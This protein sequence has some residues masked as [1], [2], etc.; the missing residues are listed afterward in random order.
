M[1]SVSSIVIVFADALL[2]YQVLHNVESALE[3]F[4][5]MRREMNGRYLFLADRIARGDERVGC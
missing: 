4:R 1:M 3:V 2:V 5:R